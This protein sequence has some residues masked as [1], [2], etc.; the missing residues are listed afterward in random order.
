M[1]PPLGMR[2]EA[3]GGPMDGDRVPFHGYRWATT[4]CP[5]H[6]PLREGDGRLR[7]VYNVEFTG[8]IWRWAYAGAFDEGQIM[9]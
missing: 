4:G 6:V 5:G 9:S 8:E 7:H 1:A 3:F 2:L